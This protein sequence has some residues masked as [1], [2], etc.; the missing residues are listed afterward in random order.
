MSS[1]FTFR[2][3]LNAVL[4]L[5]TGEYFFGVGVG[6]CGSVEGE[7]C[8]NTGMTGY[9]E[10]LTDPS[11]ANQIITFTFPHI[12]NVGVN[13]ED[14]ECERP[15]CKGLVI[16]ED[17]TNASNF[18][19]TQHLNAWLV[20]NGLTGIA[21]VDTR[22]L[23][24]IVR[25]KGACHVLIYFGTA[26]ETIDVQK[27][28]ASIV[29]RPSLLGCELTHV[30]TTA[31]RYVWT[32]K[33]FKLGQA[34]FE[35]MR[36]HSHTVVALD[37]GIK[38]NILRLLADEGFR[39]VVMPATSTFEEIMSESPDGVF[40]SNGP[41][42]PFETSRFTAP[43]LRQLLAKKVP[44]FGICMGHQLLALAQGMETVKMHKGHRGTNQ[45]VQHLASKRVYIT[46]Q[47]HGFCVSTQH[48]SDDVEI[49][50]LSL[51]DQSVEGL[52]SKNAPAFSVQFH[53]ESSPG[54][55]DTRFLFQ[56]FKAMILAHIS[57]KEG[58]YAKTN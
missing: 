4:V 49:T 51:F 8:F 34:F 31:S 17:I 9:Q 50:Y 43:V 11:Y 7:I 30:V 38:R 26:G 36:T 48:I 14:N 46:S 35:N 21:G 24:Q 39:V 28:A 23:T 52:K 53:P 1:L 29:D 44:I 20:Q 6:Q 10:T 27:L 16:R 54:P 13:L 56:E 2:E 15:F 40:L 37:Y 5:S 47:N 57:M 42:D 19:A 41:G 45:P 32:E 33:S 12:G 55:H 3:N 58:L 25:D 22:A 18:R